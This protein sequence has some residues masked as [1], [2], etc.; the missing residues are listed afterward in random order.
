GAIRAV[1]EPVLLAR[2]RVFGLAGCPVGIGLDN[3]YK[4][5]R[6]IYGVLNQMFPGIPEQE[7]ALLIQDPKHREWAWR[8]ILKQS[9]PDCAM[10]KKDLSA[11]FARVKFKSLLYCVAAP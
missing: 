9:Q 6:I 4:F 8:G 1:L 11:I 5:E 7:Q 10:G 2:S 3:V